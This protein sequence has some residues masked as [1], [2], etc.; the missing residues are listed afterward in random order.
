VLDDYEAP[1]PVAEMIS[2]GN[3][4]HVPMWWLM[5][6]LIEPMD[7]DFCGHRTPRADGTPPPSAVRFRPCDIKGQSPN[8]SVASVEHNSGGHQPESSAAAPKIITRVTTK[9]T[10]RS[11]RKTQQSVGSGPADI[12]ELEPDLNCS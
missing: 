9:K 2:I 11:M 5:N 8:V 12:D 1:L 6:S 4:R 10:T 3:S 7:L